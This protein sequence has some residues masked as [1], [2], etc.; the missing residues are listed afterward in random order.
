MFLLSFRLLLAT[1]VASSTHLNSS[2][3]PIVDLGY[4]RHQAIAYNVRSSSSNRK[5]IADKL[6]CLVDRSIL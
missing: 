1:V 4:E 5:K 2:V 6:T 3:L